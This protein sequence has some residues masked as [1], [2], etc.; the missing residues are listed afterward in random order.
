MRIGI[1]SLAVIIIVCMAIWMT[2][3]SV[4]RIL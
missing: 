2:A 1:A 3:V 4:T